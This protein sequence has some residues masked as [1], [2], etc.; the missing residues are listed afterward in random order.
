MQ[1]SP[2][3]YLKPRIVNVEVIGKSSRNSRAHGKRFWLYFR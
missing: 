1:N 2:T 3:E